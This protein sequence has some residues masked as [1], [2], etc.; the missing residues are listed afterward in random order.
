MRTSKIVLNSS[1]KNKSGAHERIFAALASGAIVATSENEYLKETFQEQQ[2]I[3][4]YKNAEIGKI[5]E[6]I[7]EYTLR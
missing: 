5:N 4:F 3:L 7:H 6:V 2:G 1:I